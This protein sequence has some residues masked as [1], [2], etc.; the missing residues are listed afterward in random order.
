MDV[1]FGD[2]FGHVWFHRNLSTED[3]REFDLKGS[4]LKLA[5]GERIK[6]GP[7][8]KDPTRDFDALQGARTVLTVADF[9]RDGKRDLVVGDTYG[10]IR[11]FRNATR[12]KLEDREPIFSDPVEIAD[13]R[14]RGLVETTDW[15]RDGWPDVIASAANGRVQVL[16]NKGRQAGQDSGNR[17]ADG[18]DPKLPPII[19]PRVLT[20][21]LNADGDEDLF[22]PS[23]QGSCFVERSFLEK[24]YANAEL[25]AQQHQPSE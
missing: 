5:S 22:L 24:G 8:G 21:D 2:W 12:V 13:L 4:R 23:T 3:Q 11:Y 25:L 16:L 1:L 19:Q 15:N 6:V 10:K 20:A 9:D 7:L 18:F 17:F 14:I